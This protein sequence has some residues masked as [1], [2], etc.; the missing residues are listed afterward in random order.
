MDPLRRYLAEQMERSSTNF[1]NAR[2]MRNLLEKSLRRQ[3]L[4]LSKKSYITR[5]ELITIEEGDLA[6]SVT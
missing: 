2:L 1:S 6:V 5:E 4:R 3:A